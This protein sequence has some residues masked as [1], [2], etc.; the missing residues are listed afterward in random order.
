MTTA[1]TKTAKLAAAYAGLS[2]KSM[3]DFKKHLNISEK[4]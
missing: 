4:I 2:Y 3:G 1:Q